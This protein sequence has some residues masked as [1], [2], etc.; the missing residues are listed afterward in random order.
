[1]FCNA[2]RRV[3]DIAKKYRDIAERNHQEREDRDNF[4]IVEINAQDVARSHYNCAPRSR[5]ETEL[6]LNEVVR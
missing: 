5:R 6:S 2:I 3:D 4:V 1:M